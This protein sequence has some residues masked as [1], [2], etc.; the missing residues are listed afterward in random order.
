VV[1][2]KGFKHKRSLTR[3]A[4]NKSRQFAAIIAN[5]N[6]FPVAGKRGR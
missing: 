3:G 5:S 2:R 1:L 6:D 4:E